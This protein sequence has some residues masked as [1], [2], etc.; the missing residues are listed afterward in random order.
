[1]ATLVPQSTDDSNSQAGHTNIQAADDHEGILQ[2]ST[3]ST[4][5]TDSETDNSSENEAEAV[6]RTLSASTA[7]SS[8]QVDIE[9]PTK[10][11]QKSEKLK[12]RGWSL[13]LTA[14]KNKGRRAR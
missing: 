11:A 14:A 9:T 10:E 5:L 4:N 8:A 6:E 12:L 2:H 13:G 7:G 1:M 3:S